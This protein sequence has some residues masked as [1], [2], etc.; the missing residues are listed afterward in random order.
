[1]T[2]NFFQPVLD[3]LGAEFGPLDNVVEKW[4]ALAPNLLAHLPNI[5]TTLE[6]H[7]PRE[8]AP[9]HIFREGENTYRSLLAGLEQSDETATGYL[10]L[11]FYI[12]LNGFLS[13]CQESLEKYTYNDSLDP[14]A[15]V[16]KS[17]YKPFFFQRAD[18]PTEEILSMLES[19]LTQLQS[20]TQDQ[21]GVLL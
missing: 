21:K 18:I 6:A 9:H 2:E 4:A 8:S 11:R 14:A 13:A 1:M 5:Y 17:Y 12:Y 3:A 20:V 7:C 10:N 19:D 15:L 16:E